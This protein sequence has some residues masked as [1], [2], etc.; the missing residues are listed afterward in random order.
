MPCQ[1][2][3]GLSPILLTVLIHQNPD[4]IS[5]ADKRNIKVQHTFFSVRI[6]ISMSELL[7]FP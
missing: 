7:D 3:T 2:D 4:A 6:W 5:N 1:F